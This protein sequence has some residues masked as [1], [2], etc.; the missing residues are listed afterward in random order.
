VELYFKFS[1]CYFILSFFHANNKATESRSGN[2]ATQRNTGDILCGPPFLLCGS[3]W[4]F[5]L[6]SVF[7]ISSFHS[8]MQTTRP[9]RTEEGIEQHREI[10]GT[11][12]AALHFHFVA[13]VELYFKFRLCHFIIATD[14]F[15]PIRF[16][17]I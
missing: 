1:L 3:L 2:R 17:I 7:V 4:N 14:I 5:I 13:P 15:L 12:S 8:P 9:Q 10:Q 16:F 6:S 11:Y